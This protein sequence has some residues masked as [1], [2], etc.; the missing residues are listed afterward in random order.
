M[1]KLP[2]ASKV[3]ASL[4]ALT[5]TTNASLAVRPSVSVTATVIVVEPFCPGTGL[6]V[7]VRF[8][9]L[10]PNS[11]FV[12]EF[13]TNIGL[14]ELPLT[15]RL[16]AGVSRTDSLYHSVQTWAG[17]ARRS[18]SYSAELCCA[19]RNALPRWGILRF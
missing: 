17:L 19:R 16:A 8:A 7:T 13:G 4:T 11:M 6:M 14:D 9:P 1:D 10:P 12:F 18:E 15:T 5:V 2:S 3:G